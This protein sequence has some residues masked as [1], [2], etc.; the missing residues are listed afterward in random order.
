VV[1]HI[2]QIAIVTDDPG[3]HGQQLKE[4]LSIHG[5]TSRYV[6][7]TECQFSFGE[8]E[9]IIHLP[10]FEDKLPL[11]VFVRGIPGGSLEQ[12]IFRLDVLHALCNLG[13]TVYNDPQAI[14]RTVD[15]TMTSFLLKRA[16]LPGP[17]TWVCESQ[18]QAEAICRQEFN[19]GRRLLMKPMFGSQGIGIQML[20]QNSGLIHEELFSGLYYLQSFI[21]RDDRNWF[22]IRVF[23]V[24]GKAQAAMLRRS[25]SWITNRAQGAHCEKH[26]LDDATRQLAEAAVNA[27]NIDYAGVDLI[28]DAEDKLQ[29]IEV[30]SIPAWWGLQ[31]VTDFNIASLIVDHFVRR[32]S[33]RENS[34]PGAYRTIDES[35][36]V[37]AN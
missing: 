7:L 29:I 30:N 17:S 8:S 22:D 4:V 23:V 11:G 24:A 34:T 28:P 37:V 26:P 10:G 35:T 1:D 6:S 20:D 3:W 13:I 18:E 15:K 16:G 33:I 2:S 12:V 9:Q 31:K 19:R 25:D 27:L 32:I 36:E 14:E 21:E 5:L